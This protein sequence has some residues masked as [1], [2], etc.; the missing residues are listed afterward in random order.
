MDKDQQ[1]QKSNEETREEMVHTKSNEELN[2]TFMHVDNSGEP[3]ATDTEPKETEK[4][5]EES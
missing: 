2:E 4:Q 5:G 3:K 1:K